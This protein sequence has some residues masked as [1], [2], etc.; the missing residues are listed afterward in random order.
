M[1]K[2]WR[3][4]GHYD[5]ETTA[6]SACAG[7]QQTSPYTPDESAKLIGIRVIAERTAAT[8]LTDGVQIRLTCTTFKPNTIHAEVCG[9]GL[10]T[11][12]AQQ[13][14]AMDFEVDQPVQAGVPISVEGRCANASA[15]T[16]DV[17]IYGMFQS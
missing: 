15:V 13:A 7:A 17:K 6:W 9:S 10:Q 2:Y 3:M 1:G 11:A 14:Q 12:P 4:I 16:N 5:A 8:T